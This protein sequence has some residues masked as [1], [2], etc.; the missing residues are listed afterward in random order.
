[1]QHTPQPHRV[2]ID[3][4]EVPTRISVTPHVT[5]LMEARGHGLARRYG[6]CRIEAVVGSTGPGSRGDASFLLQ[7]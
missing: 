2:G 6:P 4:W 5:R 3:R 7:R 1:M